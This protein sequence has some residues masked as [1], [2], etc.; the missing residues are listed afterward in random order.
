MSGD[1][2]LE[3]S[4]QSG[5]NKRR[6]SRVALT[7]L[8]VNVY[9]VKDIKANIWGSPFFQR[10]DV[11]AI[12]A[13]RNEVNADNSAS[14]IATN[15]EDFEIYRVGVF[16]ENTGALTGETPALL[17]KGEALKAQQ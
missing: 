9:S 2:A 7:R 5:G 16:D 10:N 1:F 12:R 17:A 6:M 13:L 3:I 4:D 8:N 14:L 15:P 11:T